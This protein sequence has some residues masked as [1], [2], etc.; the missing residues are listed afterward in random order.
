MIG[1]LVVAS[2]NAGKLREI[3]EILAPLAIESMPEDAVCV[4]EAEGPRQKVDENAPM[5]A[6]HAASG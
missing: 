3:G 5:K 6:R 1:R 2:G 4:S